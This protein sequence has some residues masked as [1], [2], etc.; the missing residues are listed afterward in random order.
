[1]V[2]V[3]QLL[4]WMELWAQRNQP[5]WTEPAPP[6]AS[7]GRIRGPGE[8]LDSAE[9]RTRQNQQNRPSGTSRTSR[10][11]EFAAAQQQQRS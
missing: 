4:D 10:G 1:M 2:L 11:R 3:L 8:P 9:P 7:Q 6:P 5:S